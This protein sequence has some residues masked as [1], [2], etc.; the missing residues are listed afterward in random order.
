VTADSWVL[1]R[2]AHVQAHFL[3]MPAYWPTF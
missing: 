3:I 1:S 2:P